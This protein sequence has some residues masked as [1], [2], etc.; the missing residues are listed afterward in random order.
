MSV[1]D[2]FEN[3]LYFI[4][5]QKRPDI[6]SLII[7]DWNI[8]RPGD[9]II[10]VGAGR[11]EL[12][13]TL[14]K[15]LNAHFVLS[16]IDKEKLASI[17]PH[18]FISLNLTNGIHLDFPDNYFD[19]AFCI[20]SVHHFEDQETSL[21]EIRRVLKKGGKLLIIEYE[22]ESLLTLFYRFA[23]RLQKR[24]CRFFSL[25]GLAAYLRSLCFKTRPFRINSF[26]IA[27]IAE[28]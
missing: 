15:K 4:T 13:L 11:G 9:W 25:N 12:A 20:N 1:Y 23:A 24:H 10:D 21:K 17:P 22:K 16:E 19:T 8:L 27:L 28:K 26:Q 14:L 5:R 3:I 2:L 6:A 18:P 7:N